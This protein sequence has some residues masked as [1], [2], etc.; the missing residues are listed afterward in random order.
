MKKFLLTIATLLSIGSMSAAFVAVPAFAAP[1]QQNAC[2]SIGGRYDAATGN[3]DTGGSSIQDILNTIL[4]LFSI[5]VGI[6]AVIMIM[7]GGLK[8]ITAAGDASKLTSARHTIVYAVVGLVVAGLAQFM[9]QFV[10][11]RTVK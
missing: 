3:C 4:T 9:V 5:I 8:Y 7:V 11:Q 6:A 10:I 2:E 1:P